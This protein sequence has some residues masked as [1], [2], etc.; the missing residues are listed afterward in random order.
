MKL[1]AKVRARAERMERQHST[2]RSEIVAA[3][4]TQFAEKGLNGASMRAIA[5]EAGFTTGAIYPYFANKEEIYAA[6]L[7]DTLSALHQHVSDRIAGEAAASERAQ[8]GLRGFFDYYRARPDEL[9]LGLYLYNGLN[10]SGTEQTLN[11][12]LN[13]QLRQIIDQIEQA[14]PVEDSARA[15]TKIAAGISY[16]VGLLVM[17]HS[18]RLRLFKSNAPA[19]FDEFLTAL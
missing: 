2:R 12:A 3:A 13:K 7:S 15:N 1:S 9:A 19:L 16:A 10:P 8:A 11:R 17:E 6:V 18:G 4:K 14:Y 5:G